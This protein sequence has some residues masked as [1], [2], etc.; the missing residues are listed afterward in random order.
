MT[1]VSP[2]ARILTIPAENDVGLL[3]AAARG[4]NLSLSEEQATALL[5]E[6]YHYENESAVYS[7]SPRPRGIRE[8]LECVEMHA[9]GLAIALNEL[10]A[11][12]IPPRDA[13][14]KGEAGYLDPSVVAADLVQRRRSGERDL[15]VL[16]DDLRKLS[17][18]ASEV[19]EHLPDDKKG[20]HLD[21]PR[22][23]FILSARKIFEDAGGTGRG[24]YKDYHLD[25]GYGGRFFRLV[26]AT[27]RLAMGDRFKM[28]STVLGSAV[29][30]ATEAP[31]EPQ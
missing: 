29:M 15:E 26:I 16:A 19:L 17:V 2:G 24:V 31:P 25:D 28:S 3:V 11:E 7:K 13:I 5:V 30:R 20:G 10:T 22:R 6:A 9:G 27:L 18:V 12:P 14:Q 23:E 8:L 21:L 4:F 1:N